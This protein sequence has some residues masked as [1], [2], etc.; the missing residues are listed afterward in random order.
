MTRRKR[1]YRREIIPEPVY[2]SKVLSNFINKIMMSGKKSI[3]QKIVYKAVEVLAK[4]VNE[5][6]LPAFEK[7]LKNV[8][9]QM[10]VRSRRVGGSTYQVPV[11]VKARRGQALAMRWIINFSRNRSGK[12][13]TDNLANELADAFNKTGSSIKKRED[14]HKMAD[15]NKA[16]AH[17]RW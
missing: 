7:S 14:T 5:D 16:F 9:P 6:P 15:A 1:D 4:K 13:M 3:A 11:E 8:I 2:G 17:F 10:E 12:S